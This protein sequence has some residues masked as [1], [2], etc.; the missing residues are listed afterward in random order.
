MRREL[1]FFE[2]MR[3]GV[4]KEDSNPHPYPCQERRD[5]GGESAGV[6]ARVV[7]LCCESSGFDGYIVWCA[8]GG[9]ATYHVLVDIADRQITRNVDGRIVEAGK[10]NGRSP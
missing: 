4:W 9:A 8:G 6:T 2:L 5:K 7:S 3:V 10:G 1:S